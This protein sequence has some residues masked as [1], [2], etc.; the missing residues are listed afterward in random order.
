MSEENKPTPKSINAD[1]LYDCVVRLT[2]HSP[3][4]LAPEQL[5][6]INNRWDIPE[7]LPYLRNRV[8]ANEKLLSSPVS[9]G[10]KHNQAAAAEL[11]HDTP[12]LELLT[13]FLSGLEKL[14]DPDI[15]IEEMLNQ[16]A[17]DIL[18]EKT[19]TPPAP[20]VNDLTLNGVASEIKIV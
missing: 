20:I 16:P 1:S 10:E 7:I 17:P 8:A 18:I 4:R 6:E 5:K 19:P 15:S 2:R 14:S 12:R 13:K 11:S 9:M 3:V